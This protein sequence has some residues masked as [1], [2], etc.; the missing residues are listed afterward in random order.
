[1]LLAACV[2]TTGLATAQSPRDP[3]KVGVL[4]VFDPS[5]GA[6]HVGAFKEGMRELGW[7]DGRTVHF[8]ERYDNGD[9]SR[10]P[11]LAAELV[12]LGVDVLFV[13]DGAVPAARQAISK[14]PIVCPEF[15]DPI[16]EGFTKSMAR[17]DG[18]V[19]GVSWQSV[20]GAAKRLQLTKEL[21]PGLQRVGLLFDAT[22][23][24][25]VMEARG[26]LSTARHAGIDLKT[27]EVRGPGDFEAAFAN[28]KGAQLDALLVS[29]NPL[30]FRAREKIGAFASGVRV[31]LIAETRDF[32]EAGAVLTYGVD[33]L[34]TYRRGAHFVDRI[35]K[36]AKASDLPIEQPTKFDLVLNLSA[37]KA[38][39]LKIPQS[40][41]V[42]ATKV[43]R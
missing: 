23:P 7:I 10:L 17:S 5:S 35:L 4:W 32:S 3:A 22:D 29:V 18:N 33:S 13:A 31:P 19:T 36:G 16:L 8:V 2:M 21:I 41:A 9:A 24:G 38:L 14:I 27:V 37:A 40:I 25:A 1:M 20:E 39:G 34:D 15:V 11:R 26:L 28:L 12:A 6:P 30:T 42:S 43:I